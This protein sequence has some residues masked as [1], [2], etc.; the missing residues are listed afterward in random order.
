MNALKHFVIFT[1]MPKL[2]FFL[3]PPFQRNKISNTNLYSSFPVVPSQVCRAH[4]PNRLQTV[5]LFFRCERLPCWA[6]GPDS[7]VTFRLWTHSRNFWT[8]RDKAALLCRG[9]ATGSG[10]KGGSR[11][12]KSGHR[13]EQPESHSLYN[14]ADVKTLG[15]RITIPGVTSDSLQHCVDKTHNKKYERLHCKQP[16]VVTTA[17]QQSCPHSSPT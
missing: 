8:H 13:A 11:S 16:A 17:E 3:M 12:D 4:R 5:E 15:N 6:A 1:F 2:F 9:D 14:G 7:V 10:G